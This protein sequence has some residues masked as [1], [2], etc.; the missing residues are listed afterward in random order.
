MPHTPGLIARTLTRS[1]AIGIAAGMR[2][3]VPAAAIADAARTGRLSR[4]SGPVWA[5]LRR[6]GSTKVAIA[7][8]LGEMVGDKLPFTPARTT[9]PAV[10]GRIASGSLAGALVASGLGAKSGGLVFAGLAGAAGAAIGTYGG[11]HARRSVTESGIP[12]LPIAVVEDVTALAIG[13]LAVAREL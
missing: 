12:D 4:G 8:M 2:S 9:V 6:D 13:R 7:L 3:Q 11:Y 1:F 10:Y 5:A